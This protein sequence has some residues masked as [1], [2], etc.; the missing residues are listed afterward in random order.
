M[1]CRRPLAPSL[2]TR[3]LAVSLLATAA[4]CSSSS[5]PSVPPPKEAGTDAHVVKKPDA[6]SGG[7]EASTGGSDAH[8]DVIIDPADCVS[9][10]AKPSEDGIGS[11]CSPGGGQCLHAGTGGVAT[12]CTADVF[13]PAHEWFCTVACDTTSDCGPGGGTCIDAPFGQIC[14]PA[15]CI[16]NLGDAASPVVD[17]GDAASASDATSDHDAAPSHDATSDVAADATHVS[18]D[19]AADASKG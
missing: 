3:L 17:A 4:A 16:A 14:V 13:A 10:G 7:M 15:A 6:T 12:L 2:H 19:A 5:T 8:P 1:H 18:P 9:V 11:Y